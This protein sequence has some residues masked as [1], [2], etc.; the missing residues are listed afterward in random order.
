MCAR[1]LVT[2]TESYTLLTTPS[3]CSL[4]PLHKTTSVEEKD[5]VFKSG[6]LYLCAPFSGTVGLFKTYKRKKKG[7]EK[8]EGGIR[9]RKGQNKYRSPQSS[10]VEA[11]GGLVIE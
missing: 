1:H 2:A 8:L 9:E 7:K 4:G 6:V 10:V 3:G 11:S 5:Q